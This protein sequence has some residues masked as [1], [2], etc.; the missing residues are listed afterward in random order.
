MPGPAFQTIVVAYDDPTSRTLARAADV[1]A[2]L[3]SRLIVAN[4]AA[5]VESD[6]EEVALGYGRKRLEEARRLLDERGVEAELV[7]LSGVPAEAIVRLA[8]DRDAD[9]IVIGTRRKKLFDRIVEGS[10]SR[11]VMRRAR[12]DVLAVN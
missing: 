7:P 4:V 11:D 9:L 2:A 1:A 3:G 10:V 8:A 6:D 5:A 12:C